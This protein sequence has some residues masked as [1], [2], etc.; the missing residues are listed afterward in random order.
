METTIKLTSKEQVKA[1][2]TQRV[3]LPVSIYC[4]QTK[5]QKGQDSQAIYYERSYPCTK[6]GIGSA[7]I[8]ANQ[9]S[10]NGISFT[11]KELDTDGTVLLDDNAWQLL[12]TLLEGGILGNPTFG[13]TENY[14][15]YQ[16]LS[17]K[18]ADYMLV[19]A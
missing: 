4:G 16:I 18:E 1:L 14:L 6:V 3:N 12:H 10:V 11:I 15:T 19:T 7:L 13:K 5:V 2:A 17:F 8:Q 9:R